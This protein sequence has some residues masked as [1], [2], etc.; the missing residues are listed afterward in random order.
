MSKDNLPSLKGVREAATRL[1]GYSV[2]T[3][4]LES[5]ILNDLIKFQIFL[6]TTRENLEEIKQEEFTY[7]WKNYFVN[8]SGIT[9]SKMN[10]FYKNKITE[11]DP[12]KWTLNVIWYGR[13]EVKYKFFPKFLQVNSLMI[14]EI[15]H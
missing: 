12:V 2:L 10:Y 13:K 6:L 14:D 5:E 15:I 9:K 11:K 7:D 1:E 3:P 8:N 4:V